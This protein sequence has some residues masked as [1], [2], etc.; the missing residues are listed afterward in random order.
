MKKALI[1]LFCAFL[2]QQFSM[3]ETQEKRQY[4]AKNINPRPPVIDGK[5]DDPVWQSGEW[6]DNF[7]QREPYEGKAP[8][9]RTSFKILYDDKNLYIAIR[10]SDSEPEKTVKRI[11]RRDGR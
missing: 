2:V 1:I 10:A 7:T 6:G 5:L 9:Q 3:A 4:T 8:T 11:S